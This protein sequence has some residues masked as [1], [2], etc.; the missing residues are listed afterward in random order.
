MGMER[1]GM[2]SITV[3]KLCD[4]ECNLGNPELKSHI[5]ASDAWLGSGERYDTRE[6]NSR[7]IPLKWHGTQSQCCP[8][9]IFLDSEK[10]WHSC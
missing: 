9:R 3:W 7:S 5:I 10:E 1:S 4:T 8:V 6:V 2:L